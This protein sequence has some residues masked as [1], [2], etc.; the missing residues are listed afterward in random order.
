[1][2]ND[3]EQA[4][5]NREYSVKMKQL[6]IQANQED[7]QAE[8]LL[9]EMKIRWTSLLKVPHTILRLPLFFLLGVAYIVAAITGYQPQRGFWDL[10]K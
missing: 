2:Q 8:I 10:L 6:E 9:E 5:L 4:Q 1:M 7:K 3:N